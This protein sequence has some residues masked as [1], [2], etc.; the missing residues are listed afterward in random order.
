MEKVDVVLLTKNSDRVL[1]RCLNSIYRSIPINRLIVVDGYST[2][3]TTSILGEFDKKYHNVKMVYD[4]GTRATARQKGIEEVKTDWFVFVDSDVVLCENWYEKAIVH[5]TEGVGAVWGIEVWSTIK[6]PRT[7][8]MFL[9]ITRKIFELR[10]GTHDTLIRTDL[11]KG[12]E[13]PANLHVFE[14]AYLKNWVEKK[15]FRVIATYDPF[16]IHYRPK[17]VWTLRGSLNII[18]DA[19]KFGNVGLLAKLVFAYGFYVAYSG[20]Q[21]LS[22]TK[23]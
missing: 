13:I 19:I 23:E 4:G 11:V 21:L 5:V 6:N 1:V 18:V 20:Y 15:G 3:K 16:C 14:D 7:L 17:T 12:I 22:S 8:K 9:W 10:G 2:D